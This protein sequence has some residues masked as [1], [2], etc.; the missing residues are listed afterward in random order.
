MAGNLHL[1]LPVY[2]HL[3]FKRG[4]YLCTTS[5]MPQIAEGRQFDPGQ[6]CNEM[7]TSAHAIVELQQSWSWAGGQY[8][9][10]DFDSC[11]LCQ[12]PL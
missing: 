3:H 10:L 1:D 9:H 7:L 6:V 12:L 2:L 4:S 8:Q 5:C 11:H